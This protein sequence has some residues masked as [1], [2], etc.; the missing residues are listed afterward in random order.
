MAEAGHAPYAGK[1]DIGSVVCRVVQDLNLQLIPR[2]LDGT[3]TFDNPLDHVPFVEHGKLN[4]DGGQL[5]EVSQGFGMLAMMAIVD[6][7]EQVT[8]EAIEN[9][10]PEHE[11]VKTHEELLKELGCTE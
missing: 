3:G 9:H 8:V 5:V 7:D 6:K 10:G 2:I 11:Y 1:N 4:G